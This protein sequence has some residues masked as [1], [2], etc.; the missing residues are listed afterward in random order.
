MY[1]ISRKDVKNLIIAKKKRFIENKLN[2]NIGKPKEL[3]KTQNSLGMPTKTSSSSN[4]CL[5][6]NG[7]NIF[8]PG[9]N[10]RDIQRFLF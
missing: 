5:T 2:E 8:Q 3:W 9:I 4:I 1:K 7:E 6:N 10:N